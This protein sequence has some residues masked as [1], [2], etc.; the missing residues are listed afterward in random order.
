MVG[1]D[2]SAELIEVARRRAGAAGPTYRVDDAQALGSVAD[3]AFDVVVSQLAMMDVADHR[4]LF[5]TVRRVLVPGGPFVFS[6][7][8]PCFEGRPFHIRDAPPSS[9]TTP[10]S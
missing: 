9:W 1:I 3:G 7:L 10:A 6:V 2:L 8:H 4:K 5:A